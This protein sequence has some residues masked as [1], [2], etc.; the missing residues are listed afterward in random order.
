MWNAYLAKLQAQAVADDKAESRLRGRALT[1]KRAEVH[2]R[3]PASNAERG[4][5]THESSRTMLWLFHLQTAVGDWLADDMAPPPTQAIHRIPLGSSPP[6]TR[7]AITPVY[8][9]DVRL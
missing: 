6:P 5:T 9:A 7:L 4:R 8:E 3:M 2:I 1:L